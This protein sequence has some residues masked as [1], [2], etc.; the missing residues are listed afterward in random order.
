M[1]KLLFYHFYLFTFFPQD[2]KESPI[3]CGYAGIAPRSIVRFKPQ[4]HAALGGRS[5]G[6][7][8]SSSKKFIMV[9]T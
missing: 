5:S 1:A 6:G 2:E 4:I 7:S 9:C 3:A 8:E